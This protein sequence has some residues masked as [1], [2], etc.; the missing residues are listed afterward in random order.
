[1]VRRSVTR[2]EPG[3][4]REGTLALGDGDARIGEHPVDE[5]LGDG[6]PGLGARD[7]GDPAPGVA[8]LQAEVVI[9]RHA[10]SAQLGDPRRDLVD[11]RLDRA[12]AAQAAT[13]DERVLDVQRQ[14]VIGALD[15][16]DPALGE[17]A[18]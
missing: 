10:P 15:R 7:V 12:P 18:R 17:P 1:M 13:R 16:G 2:W 4:S 8:A 11:E 6:T 9:E 5:H 14:V 3:T